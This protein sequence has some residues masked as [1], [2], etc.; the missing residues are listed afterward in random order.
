MDVHELLKFLTVLNAMTLLSL[1]W[2]DQ[3][4]VKIS[5]TSLQ[6]RVSLKLQQTIRFDLIL[7]YVKESAN[8]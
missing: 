3:S 7:N 1:S 5:L 4:H 6:K 8:I 2:K